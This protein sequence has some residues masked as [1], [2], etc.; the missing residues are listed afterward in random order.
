MIK[1]FFPSN[2]VLL[3]FYVVIIFILLQEFSFD[4]DLLSQNEQD[5]LKSL[6]DETSLS[7]SCV[8]INVSKHLLL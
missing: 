3:F 4:L 8:L 5:L 2:I 7:E 1:N 6:H